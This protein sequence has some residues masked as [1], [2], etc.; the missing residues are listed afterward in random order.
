[1]RAGKAPP[2][3]GGERCAQ[4]CTGSGA[5]QERP[6][7]APAT[8][9]DDLQPRRRR[10]P[11]AGPR[12]GRPARRDVRSPGPHQDGYHRAR[13]FC[14]PNFGRRG[15]RLFW[16]PARARR[17]RGT[18]GA[19]RPCRDQG[20]RVLEHPVRQAAAS[21]RCRCDRACRRRR[22]EP[23]MPQSAM[24]CRWRRVWRRL[25]SRARW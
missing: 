18:G 19:R 14:R 17:R 12:P 23:T 11:F 13:W 6:A 3:R 16:I 1:M 24:P 2:R 4:R 22:S 9:G 20:G 7:G 21:A 8:L 5:Q 10:R 15:R 25:P